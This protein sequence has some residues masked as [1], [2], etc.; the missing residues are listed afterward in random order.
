MADRIFSFAGISRQMKK[1]FLCALRVS[2]VSYD[3][4]DA[5]QANDPSEIRLAVPFGNFT[6]QAND[7]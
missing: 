7:Q 5:G 1:I 2:V 6:G 3:P 4:R